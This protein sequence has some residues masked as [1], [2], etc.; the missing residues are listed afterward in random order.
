M[1]AK[2]IKNELKSIGITEVAETIRYNGRDAVIL[3]KDGKEEIVVGRFVAENDEYR[4]YL[5]KNFADK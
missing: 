5:A 3:R 1:N 4:D 2:Q